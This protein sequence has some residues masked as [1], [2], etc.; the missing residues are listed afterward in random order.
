MERIKLIATLTLAM[1]LFN[2]AFGQVDGA[3][4]LWTNQHVDR[5]L[6]GK[7]DSFAVV[8]CASVCWSW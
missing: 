5:T 6:S 8:R 3:L 7:H 1:V 2:M 4:L